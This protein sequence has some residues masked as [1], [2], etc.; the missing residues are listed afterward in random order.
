MTEFGTAGYPDLVELDKRLGDPLG[1][2]AGTERLYNTIYPGYNNVVRHLRVY[3]SLCWMART[4]GESLKNDPPASDS[5]AKERLNNALEKMQIVFLWANEGEVSGL[6]VAGASRTFP[7]TNE[8]VPLRFE[9]WESSAD[10]LA[11]AAYGPSITNGLGFLNRQRL[12]NPAGEALAAA[13][14]QGLPTDAQL[15]W[16]RDVNVLEA[17]R[18]QIERI[19]GALNLHAPQKAEKEAFLAAFFPRKQASL[20]G[21]GAKNRWSGI[22]LTLSAIAASLSGSATET[23]IRGAMAR[24]IS[25]SGAVV[26]KPG[27]EEM[28]SVWAV[29]QLQQLQRLATETLFGAVLVWIERNQLTGAGIDDCVNEMAKSATSEYEKHSIALSS[30]LET[31]LRTFQG[32]HTSFYEA[33]ARAS[34]TPVDVLQYLQV[35]GGAGSLQWTEGGCR[36]VAEAVTTLTFVATEVLNLY[37]SAS[38]K[39]VLNELS[40]ERGSLI[41]LARGQQ[42]FKGKPVSQW[43]AHLVTDWTFARYYEVVTSRSEGTNGKLRFAFTTGESGLEMCGPHAEPF[44][45]SISTDKLLH[46]L[47]LCIQCGLVQ[48][49]GAGDQTTYALTAAGRTRVES[50]EA[51]REVARAA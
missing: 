38:H 36:A 9:Y 15:G 40:V 11:N 43:I 12:C 2:A 37:E 22:H 13:F 24:G 49:T 32:G 18:S 28:Q 19:Q 4:V 23:E 10:L 21:A 17:R 33:A 14:E 47:L 16:L 44:K 7:V 42:R 41:S 25:A 50:Y 35:V 6:Q 30:D 8:L 20:G 5:A 29:L 26:F 31:Y 39:K 46:T 27:L 48:S 3:S 1:F 45:P 51:D 34:G